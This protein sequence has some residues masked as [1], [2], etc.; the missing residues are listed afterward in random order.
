MSGETIACGDCGSA[1]PV[2][3][4]FCAACGTSL[5]RGESDVRKTVTILFCDMVGSTAIGERSDP[6]VLRDLMRRYHA[7]LRAVLERHGGAVEKFVGDA[8][9]A[10]FGIPRTHEDDPLRAVRAAVEMRDAVRPVE[11]RIGVN[12]GEVV[13]GRGETLVTGD[14]VNVAARLE[15]AARGGEILIGPTT[16]VLVRGAVRT[17][18]VEPLTLKG[19]AEPVPAFSVQGL[20]TG[21]EA[22]PRGDATPFVGRAAELAELERAF[23]AAVARRVPQ[24]VTVVGPP[25][26]GKSRLTRELLGRSGAR[27]LIGRC[28]SYG[29][30]ITFRPL[31]EIARQ[32]GD[33]RAA[34][35]TGDDADLAAARIDAALGV[36]GAAASPEE[37][38]WGA[39]RV[40]EALARSGP[41]VVVFD[42]IHWAEPE[43]LDLIE[44][45]AAFAQDV[46]LVLMCTARPELFEGRPGWATPR[47]DTLVLTLEPLGGGDTV[48]LVDQLGDIPA[49]R[50]RRI[51]EAAEGNP[52]FVEQLVAMLSERGSEG[53]AIPPTLQALLATRIDG[54]AAQE[55]AVLERGS[56][57]G[58]VFHRGGVVQLLPEPQRA[59]AGAQLLALVRKSLIRP[60]RT[61][62]PG[63]DGFRF[64]HVLIRDA[65]YEAMPKRQRAALHE[66][67]ADWLA[68]RLGEL[69]PVEI[70]GYHLEQAYGYG[71]E[72]GSPDP[73]LGA[74]A[75]ERLGAAARGARERMDVGAASNLFGRAAALVP[76]GHPLRPALLLGH[77]EALVEHGA[78]NEGRGALARAA[79]LA[80]SASDARVEWLARLE[81]A[82]LR[83]SES[84]EGAADVALD[85]AR[86]AIGSAGLTGDDLV[87]ARA[88]FLIADAALLR[89]DLAEMSR[90]V[91]RALE[92]AR[93]AGDRALEIQIVTHSAPPILFGDTSVDDGMRYLDGVLGRL[94]DVPA[95]R[96]FGLHVR[97]HLL[98]RRGEFDQAR[99][100]ISAWR[101]HMRELGRLKAYATSAACVW[102]VLSLA[103]DWP[104][105]ETALRESYEILERMGDNAT[106]STIAAFLARAC[107]EQGRL[108]EADRYAAVSA[109]RGSSDDTVNEAAWRTVRARLLAARGDRE[110]AAAM[111]RTAIENADRSGQIDTSAAA[112][113]DLAEILGP[114][115][116]AARAVDE[117]LARYE[118]KGNLVGVAR[119]TAARGR[120]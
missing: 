45:V 32:I 59:G 65:A 12:T 85:E 23:A 46:P 107:Y 72:I 49:E 11:V 47:P 104:A 8:A 64:G 41:L 66:R 60:D 96:N 50:R 100:R 113:L 74:R 109:D 73:A 33:V 31:A 42:D 93:R 29:E 101:G 70:V 28:L 13:T 24:L 6:E 27:V 90:A 92:H 118:R 108:D 14:A 106:F 22:I 26:I 51:V 71:V 37:I 82:A 91:D 58:R 116:E 21:A 36:P 75:A 16:E 43:L 3:A 114:D 94:G 68:T 87:L 4:R 117:A 34:L 56:V 62:L 103:E 119:A 81:L 48:R 83:L 63:D 9:M 53:F 111:A 55:R 80:R 10:V 84:P 15:Q 35:G 18:P 67:F 78:L 102:D 17:E 89:S 69:A 105:A 97:T 1:N 120:V 86:S 88:W 99:A 2:G 112:R 30:G 5:A 54:L 39:R 44:Y 57:E 115:P 77:G 25:G 7:T 19:K 38:A 110:A 61:M 20:V 79:A 52:L 98:A 76:D 95:V 40:F